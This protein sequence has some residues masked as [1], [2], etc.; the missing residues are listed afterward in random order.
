MKYF[1]TTVYIILI[2]IPSCIS[3][4]GEK[5]VKNKSALNSTLSQGTIETG[6]KRRPVLIKKG[7]QKFEPLPPEPP[8]PNSGT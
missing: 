5:M 2:I 7:S 8:D 4:I 3:Y 1:Q 6:N